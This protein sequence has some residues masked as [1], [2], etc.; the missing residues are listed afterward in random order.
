MDTEKDTTRSLSKILEKVRTSQDAE[1][2]AR[3]AI[4][5]NNNVDNVITLNYILDSFQLD[6]LD[7]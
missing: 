3:I 5:V 4:A 7:I 1:H 2:D 6:P